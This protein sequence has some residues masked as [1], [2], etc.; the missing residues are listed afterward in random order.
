MFF[1]RTF[2][3]Q[4]YKT[5]LWFLLFFSVLTGFA[6]IVFANVFVLSQFTQYR[7][8]ET[9]TSS[10]VIVFGGGVLKDGSMT[11]LQE[12][13][14]ITA[15]R[16]YQEG[17]VERLLLSGDNGRNRFDEVSLMYQYAVESGVSAQD[18]LLDW[19]GYRTYESCY[20]AKHVFGVN[21]AVVISQMFH[22]PRISYL[23]QS[24][25]IDVSPVA[26]DMVPNSSWW[27]PKWREVLARAKAVWQAE[28]THPTPDFL[29]P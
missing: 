27:G 1:K 8:A 26:A 21:D 23:C 15:V 19:Y 14:I 7:I 16:L 5:A 25:D 17:R 20:R 9:P 4:E 3:H 29:I 24:F 22:L 6:F 13:R 10:V 11:P 12:Q 2:F 18:I 28:I